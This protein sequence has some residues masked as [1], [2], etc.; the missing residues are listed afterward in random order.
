[1]PILRLAANDHYSSPMAVRK[2]HGCVEDPPNYFA[3]CAPDSSETD[4]GACPNRENGGRR[5]YLDGTQRCSSVQCPD[6]DE[7]EAGGVG[8]PGQVQQ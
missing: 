2:R 3:A 5:E 8:R 4:S 7:H 1:M 6:A